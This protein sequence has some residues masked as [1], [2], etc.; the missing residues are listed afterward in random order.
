MRHAQ[1]GVGLLERD[2]RDV[3][4]T[5]S[6][7]LA[8]TA[9]FLN[10]FGLLQCGAFL[11]GPRG[12]VLFLNRLAADR[13][14]N[15][16]TVR[17]NRLVAAD[18]ES[19]TRLQSSIAFALN[20]PGTSGAS[21]TLLEIRRAAGMPLLARILRLQESIRPALNGASLLLFAFDPE[22]RQTPPADLLM[23]MFGL[24]PAEAEVA[25]G[26]AS[27]K[28]P[29]EIANDRSVK[30]ETIRTHSKAIFGKTRTR[31]QVE[32]A[33]LLTRLALLVPHQ[34]SNLPSKE[35]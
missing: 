15:G 1:G 33:T 24:T 17:E 32:L 29:A 8:F 2:L 13:L 35:S 6:E 10:I 12:R 22:T 28:R 14:G 27:G 31:G 4:G 3:T 11:L 20:F 16:L 5:Q 9:Y 26:I 30:L 25:I 34:E 23:R 18:R 7:K 19:D 21:A